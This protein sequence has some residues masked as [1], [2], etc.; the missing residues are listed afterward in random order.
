MLLIVSVIMVIGYSVYFFSSSHVKGITTQASITKCISMFLGMTSSLTIGLII[1]A[2]LPN[3][4][5]FSTIIAIL[6]SIGTAI[7]VGGRFGLGGILEALA[8]SLMGAMMGTML[9]AMLSSQELTMMIAIMA[10]VYLISVFSMIMI[11]MNADVNT[12]WSVLK[13]KPISFYVAFLLSVCLVSTMGV[14]H[15]NDKEV[16]NH[17]MNHTHQHS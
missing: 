1:V 10:V 6:L 12:K 17:E 15:L 13:K 7:L 9:G 8:S 3:M 14:L 11:L 2:W 16:E 4:L 5:A